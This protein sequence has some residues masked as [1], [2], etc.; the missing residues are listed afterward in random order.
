L[1]KNP[2]VKEQMPPTIDSSPRIFKDAG[3]TNITN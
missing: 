2:L 1:K 3:A